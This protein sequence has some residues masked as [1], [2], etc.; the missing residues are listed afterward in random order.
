MRRGGFLPVGLPR[1]PTFDGFERDG[2]DLFL[3]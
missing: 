3:I 2:A 1:G